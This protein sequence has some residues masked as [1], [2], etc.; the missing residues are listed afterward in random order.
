MFVIDILTISKNKNKNKMIFVFLKKTPFRR[1]SLK[2]TWNHFARE[3][4]EIK[5]MVAASLT[6]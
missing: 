1:K 6:I 3:K 4:V 2:T 5:R